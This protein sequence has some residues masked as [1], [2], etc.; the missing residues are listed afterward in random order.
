MVRIDGEEI[1]GIEICNFINKLLEIAIK[2]STYNFSV[3]AQWIEIY[4]TVEK[5]LLPK[6]MCNI[7]CYLNLTN[8]FLQA[9]GWCCYFKNKETR[10]F[11]EFY[12]P[13]YTYRFMST[14]PTTEERTYEKVDELIFATYQNRKCTE[15]EDKSI[16]VPELPLK[17]IPKRS[18]YDGFV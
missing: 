5:C 11:D 14:Q 17:S 13:V 7:L 18:R 16:Q 15:V 2:T 9:N 10:W 1:N 4:V 3:E 6:Q 8:C 12:E